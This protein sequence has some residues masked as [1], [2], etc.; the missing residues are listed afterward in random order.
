MF[1]LAPA[2]NLL[3]AVLGPRTGGTLGA[4]WGGIMATAGLILALVQE[5]GQGGFKL[6]LANFELVQ[7]QRRSV[8][9]PS[10]GYYCCY[11]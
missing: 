4:V 5:T 3:A 7:S 8:V 1:L 6:T 11:I 10:P 9:G 2:S